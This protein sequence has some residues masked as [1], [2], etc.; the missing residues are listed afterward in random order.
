M[1]KKIQHD[2]KGVAQLLVVLLAVIVIA[3]VA[4]AGWEVTKNHKSSPV[5]SKSSSTTASTTA[6]SSCLTTYH[7]NNLCKFAANSTVFD[8]SAFTATLKTDQQG[9][10]STMTLENDGKGNTKLT[11]T[12]GGQTLN[13]ITLNGNS[14][15]QTNSTGPWMEYPSGATAP[16]S[17]PT[18]SMKIGVGSSGITYKALGT[19]ACGSLTCFKYQVTDSATPNA[20][21]VAFFDNDSYKLREWQYN[22]GSGNTTDMTISYGA[23]TI[24]KPTPVQSY[25]APAQ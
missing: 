9:T 23:V 20:T 17:D 14:Y 12:G 24:S 10:A 2:E 18:S 15:V 22:D 8:K 21:Q 19:A 3:A 25:T 7:D 13:A 6:D 4:F 11:T 1:I 16:T 5:S